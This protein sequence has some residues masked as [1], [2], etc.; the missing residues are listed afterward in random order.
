MSY[1]NFKDVDMSQ[2]VTTENL[3]FEDIC[4]KLDI[5]TNDDMIK[6]L[7]N[8][9]TTTSIKLDQRHLNMMGLTLKQF[10]K[11]LK[12][13]PQIE[14]INNTLNSWDFEMLCMQLDNEMGQRF[15]QK[16]KQIKFAFK[17]YWEY[18]ELYYKFN[19]INV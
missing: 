17:K 6:Y 16:C 1:I 3:S 14:F 11:L 15:R 9:D 18:K 13:N 10:Y 4:Q 2:Y 19:N 7:L 5:D 8:V 12:A